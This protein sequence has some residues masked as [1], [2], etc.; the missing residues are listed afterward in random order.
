[1]SAGGWRSATLVFALPAWCGAQLMTPV[2]QFEVEAQRVRVVQREVPRW[3]LRA[4]VTSAR[5]CMADA[6]G[7]CQ[8]GDY[9]ASLLAASLSSLVLCVIFTMVACCCCCNPHQLCFRWRASPGLP[10]CPGD[11]LTF[12]GYRQSQVTT[13][14]LAL[15]IALVLLCLFSISGWEGRTHVDAGIR[16][17]AL[18]LQATS[19]DVDERVSAVVARTG[20]AL[21]EQAARSPVPAPLAIDGRALLRDAASLSTGLSRVGN[22]ISLMNSFRS[23]MLTTSLVLPLVTCFAGLVAALFNL[24]PAVGGWGIATCISMMLLWLVLI[25]HFPLIP[26]FCDLCDHIDM[27][28]AAGAP[29]VT[30]SFTGCANGSTFA[31]I[32]GTIA[33]AIQRSET[34]ACA[35][36]AAISLAGDADVSALSCRPAALTAAA[37]EPIL[38]LACGSA[39]NT[40]L[41]ECAQSCALA[42]L[43]ATCSPLEPPGEPLMVTSACPADCRAAVIADAIDFRARYVALRDELEPL[44]AC[45]FVK[46]AYEVL[47]DGMCVSLIVGLNSVSTAA[48]TMGVTVIVAL[49]VMTPL[50]K[51]FR[52]ENQFVYR[53][54]GLSLPSYI[55]ARR[56]EVHAESAERAQLVTT[57]LWNS[58]SGSAAARPAAGK[59]SMATDAGRHGSSGHGNAAG[60]EG[61]AA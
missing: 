27:V 40:S 47:Y 23:A 7:T 33:R 2:G 57:N 3:N 41:S 32:D 5:W 16:Q 61:A 51:L 35:G 39:R 53:R 13:A 48:T 42:I 59:P 10:C 36:L 29:S 37:L 22:V 52:K 55:R 11:E 4:E 49:L 60:A 20:D 31:L 28:V 1:M 43:T 12:R 44:L 45:A 17:L 19:A 6:D 18:A 8:W 46:D 15:L 21:R 26:I 14:R 38:L 24:G 58:C 25:L 9:V 50:C 54:Y 34:L 30:D 56:D